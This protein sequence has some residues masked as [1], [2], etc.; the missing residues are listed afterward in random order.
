MRP[1]DPETT[2]FVLLADTDGTLRSD[3]EPIGIAVTSEEEAKRYVREA[4]VGYRHAY[5][6]VVVVDDFAEGLRQRHLKS[7]S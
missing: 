6:R 7:T 3:A 5:V 2:V 1:T 4:T